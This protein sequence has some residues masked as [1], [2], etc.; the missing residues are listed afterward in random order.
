MN[1]GGVNTSM[2]DLPSNNRVLNNQKRAFIPDYAQTKPYGGL[3][4]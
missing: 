1:M 4:M 2:P 3:E